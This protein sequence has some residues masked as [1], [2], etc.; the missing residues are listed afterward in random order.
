MAGNVDQ[1]DGYAAARLT[2][3]DHIEQQKIENMVVLTGDIH[4]SWGLEIS[5]D[6]YLPAVYDP[7][8]SQG[9]LAVEFVAPGVTS[10][11]LQDPDV[12][13]LSAQALYKTQPHL[14]YVDLY[15]QGYLL[16]DITAAR[17]QAEWYFT[18]TISRVTSQEMLGQILLTQAGSN[19]LVTSEMPSSPTSA[20]PLPAP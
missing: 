9:A 2:L 11:A 16:L 10:P 3:L 12:A 14:R 4:S 6:P 17:T 8:T 19:R 5:K 7:K 1:W 18:P 13:E 20:A 15:H